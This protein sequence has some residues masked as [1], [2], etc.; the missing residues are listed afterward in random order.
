MA[1]CTVKSVTHHGVSDPIKKELTNSTMW[2]LCQ[3][4]QQFRTLDREVTAQLV[5]TFLYIASHN[6]CHKQAL[7]E[8]LDFSTASASR[9]V[10]W[11]SHHHRLSKPGLGLVMKTKDPTNLRR[12][13]L[14]LTP[15]GESFVQ[16][17]EDLLNDYNLE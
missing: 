2:S 14:Q 7:E 11:L 15:K 10:D 16:Q 13:I 17:I 5:V 8:E 6:P 3:I 9:N 1:R 12:Y 4:Q